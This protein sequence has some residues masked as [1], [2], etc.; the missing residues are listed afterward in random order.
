[1]SCARLILLTREVTQQRP[2]DQRANDLRDGPVD[3]QDGEEVLVRPREKLEKYGRVHWQ[4]P[5]DAEGPQGVE[6]ADGC[7]VW[8]AGGDEAPDGGEPEGEVERPSASDWL[9]SVLD[10]QNR[11]IVTYRYHSRNPR[12]WPLLRVQCSVP[13]SSTGV[14]LG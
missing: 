12:T 10:T 6:D 4:V 11:Q 14:D 3:G 9:L 1:M 2:R 8:G 13:G 5:A 7:K